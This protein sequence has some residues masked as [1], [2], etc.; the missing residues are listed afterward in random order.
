MVD[1]YKKQIKKVRPQK[2]LDSWIADLDLT[3]DAAVQ[4]LVSTSV[5]YK[6]MS[7][8]LENLT[9]GRESDLKPVSY[10]HLDVYK[11]QVEVCE[12]LVD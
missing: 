7:E 9:F 8:F 12:G 5:F 6:N 3:E 1:K 4:K 2:L 11:R 10:T